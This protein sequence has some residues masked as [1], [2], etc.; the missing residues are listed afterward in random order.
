MKIELFCVRE[1]RVQRSTQS[2]LQTIDKRT[3]ITDFFCLIAPVT[4]VERSLASSWLSGTRLN[5]RSFYNRHRSI[6]HEPYPALHMAAVSTRTGHVHISFLSQAGSTVSVRFHEAMA[7]GALSRRHILLEPW[8][9]ARNQF[10]CSRYCKGIS[11]A[12]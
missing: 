6:R 1:I 2:E 9:V 10:C 7:P 3:L 12:W 4:D 8:P 5:E 11:R